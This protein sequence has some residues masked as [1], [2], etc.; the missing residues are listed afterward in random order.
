LRGIKKKLEPKKPTPNRHHKTASKHQQ[1]GST[2]VFQK[3]TAWRQSCIKLF[4]R[5]SRV[6]QRRF[7]KTAAKQQRTL[8]EKAKKY[9]GKSSVYFH[10]W[11]TFR[12]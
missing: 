9:A 10:F 3:Y 8:G 1:K 2:K 11:C 12:L 5:L 4:N 7:I 6:P